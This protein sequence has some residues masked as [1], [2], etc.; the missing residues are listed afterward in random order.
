[1]GFNLNDYHLPIGRF[2][3]FGTLANAT[4]QVVIPYDGKL[5]RLFVNLPSVALDAATT[6]NVFKNGVDTG[7]NAVTPASAAASAGVEAVLDGSVE[8][9]AGDN[10]VLTSGGEQV[11]AAVADVI[12]IIT[13]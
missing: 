10:I 7:V 3:A 8:F 11:A 9:K 1:M 13:R 12:A 6:I 2:S 4:Q 5:T